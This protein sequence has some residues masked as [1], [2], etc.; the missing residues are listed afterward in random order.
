MRGRMTVKYWRA[1]SLGFAAGIA[2]VA[3]A[4]VIFTIAVEPE[5]M[6]PRVFV[7]AYA[8]MG[9]C[10]CATLA[11]ERSIVRS[12][13]E[14]VWLFA[15]WRVMW[16]LLA[17]LSVLQGSEL[18]ISFAE[19]SS[20]NQIVVGSIIGATSLWAIASALRILEY[21]LGDEASPD[22]FHFGVACLALA[23]IGWATVF[24]DG[25]LGRLPIAIGIS[26][27]LA[28]WSIRKRRT[29]E[30]TKPRTANVGE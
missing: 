18:G 6:P 30:S 1:G 29:G 28:I 19:Q 27:A 15:P 3:V 2:I 17:A 12:N 7:I 16:V 5:K 8:V 23:V 11:I 10:I 21:K 13:Y 4:W 26:A 24:R 14:G 22:D 9:G 25:F 20:D